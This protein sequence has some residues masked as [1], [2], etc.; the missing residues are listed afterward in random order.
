MRE[1]TEAGSRQPGA[2]DAVRSGSSLFFR[3]HAPDFHLPNSNL[4]N[5]PGTSGTELSDHWGIWQ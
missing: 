5:A 2:E 1:K 4:G 3:L